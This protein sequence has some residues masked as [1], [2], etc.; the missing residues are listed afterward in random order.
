VSKVTIKSQFAV[1]YR[2]HII[3]RINGRKLQETLGDSIHVQSAEIIRGMKEVW[4][5]TH[6]A[7]HRWVN[8]TMVGYGLVQLL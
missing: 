3:T 7:L 1:E 4:Q 2:H 5:Q 6:Q 8:L